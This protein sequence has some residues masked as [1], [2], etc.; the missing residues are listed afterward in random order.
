[1]IGFDILLTKGYECT[2]HENEVL[3]TYSIEFDTSHKR[4]PNCGPGN[5]STK[6]LLFEFPVSGHLS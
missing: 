4:T 5:F 3:I 1:M 6:T 2:G